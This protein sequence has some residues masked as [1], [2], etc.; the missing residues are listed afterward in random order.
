MKKPDRFDT[1]ARRNLEVVVY[2]ARHIPRVAALLRREH[3]AVVRLIN[4]QLRFIAV[5]SLDNKVM[6]KDQIDGAWILRKTLL[7]ALSKRKAGK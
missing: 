1:V 2:G 5:R 6:V 4:K 3:A 7:A